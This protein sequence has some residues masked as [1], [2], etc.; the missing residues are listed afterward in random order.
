MEVNNVTK[1]YRKQLGLSVREFS[2]AINKRLINTGMS[3]SMVSRIENE[4]NEPPLSL[5]FECI[6]T[7]PGTWIASWAVDTI[8]AMYP[9]LVQSGVI[10]F[11]LPSQSTITE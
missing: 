8:C 6:A 7:Y 10:K 9:D 3:P 4:H 1:K 5:L 11:N 2:N